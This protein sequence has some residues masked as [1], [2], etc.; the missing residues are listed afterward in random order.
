VPKLAP[1]HLNIKA[2]DGEYYFMKASMSVNNDGIFSLV[3]PEELEEVCL[4]SN[5]NTADVIKDVK[6]L[7]IKSTD[8]LK[9]EHYLRARMMEYFN[10]ETKEEIVIMYC[11]RA[12]YAICE[13]PLTGKMTPDGSF[14]TGKGYNWY[15]NLNATNSSRG[16]FAVRLYAD[17]LLKTTYIR[18]TSNKIIYSGADM[19]SGSFGELLTSF[20]GCTP[21]EGNGFFQA[22]GNNEILEMPYTEEAAEFFYNTLMGVA[23]VGHLLTERFK[24]NDSVMRMINDKVRLLNND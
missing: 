23:K 1:V 16:G 9:C 24:N 20:V 12:D 18:S 2:N 22:N 8:K 6:Y 3:V 21:P 19:E 4:S 10:Y 15:G 5:D 13:D 11:F 17:I 14:V 7:K